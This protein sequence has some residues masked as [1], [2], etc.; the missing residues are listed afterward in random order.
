MKIQY[1]SE[2]FDAKSEERYLLYRIDPSELSWWKRTFKN[3]W[4]YVYV[5]YSTVFST[6]IDVHDCLGF[7]FSS[8]EANAIA[9]K[10]DTYE[11]ITNFLNAEFNKAKIMWNEAQE[12][13]RRRQNNGWKF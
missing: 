4:R 12:E 6:D 1:K 8:E 13:Y 11:K 7:I 10:Y 5:V 2:P 9:S 3:P